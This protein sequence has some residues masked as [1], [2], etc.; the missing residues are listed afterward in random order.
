M[1]VNAADQYAELILDVHDIER[2]NLF[3]N[4]GEVNFRVR[5]C[6]K[7]DLEFEWVGDLDLLSV[8]IGCELNR[9]R[10]RDVLVRERQQE[11]RK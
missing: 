7:L 2:A 6:R 3:T 11:Q 9:L 5:R 8:S 10:L 1:L 4:A